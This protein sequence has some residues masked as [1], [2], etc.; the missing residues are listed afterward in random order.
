MFYNLAMKKGIDKSSIISIAGVGLS[1][2]ALIVVFS[3]ETVF[4]FLITAIVRPFGFVG[5]WILLPFFF[6]LGLYMLLKQKLM[7]FKLGLSLWGILIIIFGFLILTSIWAAPVLNPDSEL[8]FGTVSTDYI[9]RL[10]DLDKDYFN[11]QLGGGVAGYFLAALLNSAITSIGTQIASWLLVVI[12]LCLVFN[13]E[14]KRFFVFIK[15]NK[16][17]ARNNND[18]SIYKEANNEFKEEDIEEPLPTLNVNP[19]PLFDDDLELN[20]FNNTHSLKKAQFS[21]DESEEIT[22]ETP[23]FNSQN[24]SFSSPSFD[25]DV[26]SKSSEPSVPTYEDQ[27]PDDYNEVSPSLAEYDS[28][29]NYHEENQTPPLAKPTSVIAEPSPSAPQMSVPSFQATQNPAPAPAPAPVV[30]K[31]HRPQPKANPIK[32]YIYPPITLLDY[33]E[34]SD[35]NEKNSESTQNTIDLI[36]EIFDHLNIGARVVG[37]TVGPAVTR[38][39]VQTNSNVSVKQVERYID[40]ISVRLGGVMTRFEKI[41]AGKATSGLE[42]PNAIRTNVGL[43]ESIEKLPTGP[44]SLRYIP[45]GKNISGELLSGNLAEF[46]HMLVSGTTGSGKTIFMHSVI[47]SLIMRNRPDELKIVLIDPKKVEMTYYEK[48]PHLLCPNISQSQKA[49]VAMKKLVDEME[50]RYNIFADNRVR[51]IKGF[52]EFAKANNIQPLPYIVVFVDEYADLV[53]EVK[54][55]RTPVVRIA[56]KARAAGIHLVI[57][58]QRPSVNVID[59]VIKAN[60]STRVALMVAS[61]TD[62]ITVINQ[63]GAETLLGNGD[64]IVD[65]P[66]ISKSM[67]PRVQGCFVDVPEINRVCDFLR[68]HYPEQYDPEFLDLEEKDE[69]VNFDNGGEV[70]QIDKDMAEEQ[71]YALI[72]EQI[73][74]REYCSISYIQRTYQVGFPKA[75]RLFNKLIVDGYV[76][77]GGGDARGSKVLIRS[78]NNEQQMG[79]IEQSTFI[80]DENK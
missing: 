64:M 32:N 25:D 21:F 48:I 49:Y 18:N 76:A 42:I 12:G 1:L 31:M 19:Q 71:L 39:D 62:S 52:N 8:N 3:R 69:S 38:Y 66:L 27:I 57:A 30:D 74:E 11:T 10:V 47:L 72:K 28:L 58:T 15:N 80:P 40:D 70:P 73:V 34:S 23:S 78:T 13:K 16:R 9:S 2:L 60:L 4:E 5:F 36:N 51:D 45:F 79:T 20:N 26:F 63:A 56:Q 53:E 43:R 17:K 55:I 33:H 7:K 61:Q 54:D 68:D 59:G 50:R 35:D 44:K 65:C 14:I 75:G 6:I 67:K 41:V 22:L 37:S 29:N 24:N 46:P 77:R